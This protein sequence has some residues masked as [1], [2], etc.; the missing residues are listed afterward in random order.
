METVIA[1]MPNVGTV[2]IYFYMLQPTW[3]IAR[4]SKRQS[5]NTKA[6]SMKIQHD[7]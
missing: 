7:M 4:A 3:S 5:A 6:M 1:V 2:L